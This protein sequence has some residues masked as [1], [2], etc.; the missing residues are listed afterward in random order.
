MDGIGGDVDREISESYKKTSSQLPRYRMVD[1]DWPG[2]GLDRCI[3]YLHPCCA[4]PY[5]EFCES[6]TSSVRIW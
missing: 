1:N 6:F 5:G 3:P 2:K 4:I